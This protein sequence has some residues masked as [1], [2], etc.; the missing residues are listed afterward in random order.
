[1]KCFQISRPCMDWWWSSVP[2][3][4]SWTSMLSLCV[5]GQTSPQ[6]A[7]RKH[8]WPVFIWSSFSL[9][10]PVCV[11]AHLVLT[12]KP[13]HWYSKPS[14]IRLM[15]EGISCIWMTHEEPF[16]N[17]SSLNGLVRTQGYQ[18]LGPVYSLCCR[19]KI[20]VLLPSAAVEMCSALLHDTKWGTADTG[21]RSHSCQK[22]ICNVLMLL[23]EILASK[24]RIYCRT[25]ISKGPDTKTQSFFG[26]DTNLSPLLW[27]Y[28]ILILA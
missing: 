20:K 16:K 27:R 8:K 5:I 22:C 23:N 25:G 24:C 12:Q 6:L 1:M 17:G 9:K 26:T 13:L 11:S 28:L 4:V 14:S 18:R 2:L 10:S 15:P 19:E 3:T 7:L 21:A